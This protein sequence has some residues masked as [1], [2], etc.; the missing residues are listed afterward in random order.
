MSDARLGGAEGA[1]R[2]PTAPLGDF[3]LEGGTAARCHALAATDRLVELRHLH[4]SDVL[5]TRCRVGGFELA[6]LFGNWGGTSPD[7]ISDGSINGYDLTRVLA[8]WD[9]LLGVS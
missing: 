8:C 5:D 4:V 3:G 2:M 9:P 6:L 1:E 7:I